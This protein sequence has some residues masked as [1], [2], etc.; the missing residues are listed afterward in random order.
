[1]RIP[2]DSSEAAELRE[3]QAIDESDRVRELREREA[4][5]LR[6]RR[7]HAER[8][9][10][11]WLGEDA[12]DRPIPCPVCRPHLAHVPCRL[13]SAPWQSCQSLVMIRRGPCCVEC[14]HEA[15]RG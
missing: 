15:R 9:R 4:V 2:V 1:M 5:E 11:G 8:C 14:D 13:C 7:D 12:H 6:D 3:R 10:G